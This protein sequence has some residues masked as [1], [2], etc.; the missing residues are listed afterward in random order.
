MPNIIIKQAK[1]T[2]EI[3]AHFKFNVLISIDEYTDKMLK[4]IFKTVILK[5]IFKTVLYKQ[6]TTV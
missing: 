3:K 4:V 5:V 1:W 2:R 6:N